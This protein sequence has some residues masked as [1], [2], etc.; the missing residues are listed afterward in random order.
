MRYWSDLRRHDDWEAMW[1][2]HP[3]VRAWINRRVTGDARLWPIVCLR[4]TLPGRLPLARALSVGCGVGNLERS[5]LALGLVSFVTGIDESPEAIEEAR[6]RALDAGVADRV[7]Y[8]A[9]DARAALSAERELDAVFFHASLHHFDRVGELL[10][11]VRTAL[12]AGGILYLDEYVGPSRDEWTL[13]LLAR[14]N[15]V[16]RL[17]PRGSHRT[18]LV[19]APVSREDPTEARESSRIP[20]EVASRFRVLARRDYGGNLG[21]VIYPSLLRP[22]EAFE[23]A[24][25]QLLRQE[26]RLSVEG[27]PGFF[28][29]IVAERSDELPSTG[30]R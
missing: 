16:Y 13:G 29:V 25:A 17:L 27:V 22:G 7:R 15:L 8:V 1:L 19:R 26:D 10:E 12:K 21:F 9:G 14:L 23:R 2:G 28:S 4:E 5:L 20:R 30:R 11:S 6:H 18:W 24:V 3:A